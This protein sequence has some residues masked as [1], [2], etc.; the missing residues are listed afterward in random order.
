MTDPKHAEK[1]AAKAYADEHGVK[2]TEALRAVRAP[3]HAP[4]PTTGPVYCADCDSRGIETEMLD[5]IADGGHVCPICDHAGR[6]LAAAGGASKSLP[7]DVLVVASAT[8]GSGASTFTVLLTE[9]S[10]TTQRTITVV[11]GG[12]IHESCF[13]E[14]V[15]PLLD[16]GAA[17]LLVAEPTRRSVDSA[18]RWV[19]SSAVP[20][21]TMLV[22]NRVPASA[23]LNEQA[24][25]RDFRTWGTYVGSAGLD[26]SLVG[27]GPASGGLA[28][29]P[30]FAPF[31]EAILSRVAGQP[32]SYDGEGRPRG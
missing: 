10:V 26:K 13:E 15:R 9:G 8:S 19:R 6:V 24:V 14:T 23:I 7:G 11:D 30:V 28:S 3:Q 1:K 5:D 27:W 31:V 22:F 29:R 25:E 32:K 20:S 18:F 17:L 2:Y 12:S 21:R 4:T 16:D